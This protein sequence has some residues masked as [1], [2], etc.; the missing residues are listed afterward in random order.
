MVVSNQPLMS[1]HKRLTK[2]IY[3]LVKMRIS[4]AEQCKKLGID[5][6]CV[7]DICDSGIKLGCATLGIDYNELI[8]QAAATYEMYTVEDARRK[9]KDV[10]C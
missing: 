3:R 5:A 10:Y 2:E 6:H 1:E 8:G 9:C 7:V 4:Y